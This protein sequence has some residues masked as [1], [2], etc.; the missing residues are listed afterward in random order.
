MSILTKRPVVDAQSGAGRSIRQSS[1]APLTG[2]VA[3]VAATASRRATA[4]PTAAS[5]ATASASFVRQ[6]AYSVDGVQEVILG[7]CFGLHVVD[8]G[9]RPG[10]VSGPKAVSAF[11]KLPDRLIQVVSEVH[12]QRLRQTVEE[13]LLEEHGVLLSVWAQLEKGNQELA[14]GAVSH[15]R[16]RTEAPGPLEG[17]GLMLH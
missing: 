1:C 16:S 7:C 14:R 10:A 2:L 11:R 17:G 6:K 4:A 3:V 15:I 12:L 9:A 13:G 5:L 8:D